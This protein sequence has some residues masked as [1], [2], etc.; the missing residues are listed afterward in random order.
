M[1]FTFLLVLLEKNNDPILSI[2][3]GLQHDLTNAPEQKYQGIVLQ[4]LAF[5]L[6]EENDFAIIALL[7]FASINFHKPR[8][9]DHRGQHHDITLSKSE[10]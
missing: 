3:K 5:T 1:Q 10:L 8:F 7:A 9:Y 4:S 6:G 2:S